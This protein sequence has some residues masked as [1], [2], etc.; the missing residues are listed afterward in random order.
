MQLIRV[1]VI[2][3]K[4]K[5]IEIAAEEPTYIVTFEEAGW[6]L[7]V[8]TD[9]KFKKCLYYRKKKKKNL[10]AIYAKYSC[11]SLNKRSNLQKL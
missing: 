5:I 8:S 4:L 11:H 7:V 6:E 3:T 10:P 1:V 2:A 9:W